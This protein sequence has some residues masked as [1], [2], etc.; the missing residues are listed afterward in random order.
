MANGIFA[1]IYEYACL[2]LLSQ[3]NAS[4]ILHTHF[5]LLRKLLYLIDFPD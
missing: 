2:A 4:I 5:V 3:R 1:V